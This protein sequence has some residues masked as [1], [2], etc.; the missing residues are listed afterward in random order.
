[1]ADERVGH[2]DVAEATAGTVAGETEA[3]QIAG[4]AATIGQG[5]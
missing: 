5:E 4:D 3:E 1:M 2:L